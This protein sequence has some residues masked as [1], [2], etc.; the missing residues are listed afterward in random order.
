MY[1]LF[2]LYEPLSLC[3]V[4]DPSQTPLFFGASLLFLIDKSQTEKKIC[5]SCALLPSSLLLPIHALIPPVP[6]LYFFFFVVVIFV[7]FFFFS[8]F[9]CL[10]ALLLL[11]VF[12]VTAAFLPLLRASRAKEGGRIVNVSSMSGSVRH[13]STYPLHLKPVSPCAS[14]VPLFIYFID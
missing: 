12:Q 9:G 6:F 4:F 7:L 5:L 2:L 8:L 13:S 10:L 11:P 3:P 14:P 1:C